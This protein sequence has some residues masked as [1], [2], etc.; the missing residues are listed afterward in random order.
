MEYKYVFLF[1]FVSFSI[2]LSFIHVDDEVNCYEEEVFLF[3]QYNNTLVCD[4]CLLMKWT[5]ILEKRGACATC[6]EITIN[7]SDTRVF[8]FANEFKHREDLRDNDVMDV[9]WCYIRSAG[10]YYIRGVE[11]NP[12]YS[13]WDLKDVSE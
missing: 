8:F 3:N 4:N 1:L 12:Y 11:A 2:F 7:S 5:P 10:D 9:R 13:L 6:G